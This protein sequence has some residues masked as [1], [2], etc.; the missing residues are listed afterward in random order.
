V[1]EIVVKIK[2]ANGWAFPIV[3]ARWTEESKFVISLAAKEF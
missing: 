2:M 1:N 3:R